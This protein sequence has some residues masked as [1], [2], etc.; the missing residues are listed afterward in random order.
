MIQFGETSSCVMGVTTVRD[1]VWDNMSEKAT[2]KRAPSWPYWK[3]N[4]NIH[5]Y[6]YMH[7]NNCLTF[8]FHATKPSNNTYSR[9]I[10]TFLNNQYRVLSLAETA[11][12]KIYR[13]LIAIHPCST[14]RFY[15]T[16][17]LLTFTPP[18]N[19]IILTFS[20]QLS[21]NSLP[22]P[23]FLPPRSTA[24]LLFWNTRGQMIFDD[25]QTTHL[26]TRVVHDR[27]LN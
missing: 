27:L 20:H 16:R 10:L 18:N 23:P 1:V 17:P 11:N 19:I 15:P 25:R 7:S 21:A 13:V 9:I 26:E 6:I 4:C 12:P 8:P 3:I 2:S 22:S 14:T 5:T 24:P